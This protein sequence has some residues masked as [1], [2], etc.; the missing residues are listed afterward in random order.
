MQRFSIMLLLLAL[1]SRIPPTALVSL[2]S[3][4]NFH[5]SGRMGWKRRRK[6]VRPTSDL[7]TDIRLM[8]AP[9]LMIMHSFS[10]PLGRIL[11]LPLHILFTHL[12]ISIFSLLFYSQNPGASISPC[13]YLY[14]LPPFT[15]SH[16]R[17]HFPFPD[18]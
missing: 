1:P 6:V 2:P 10:L 4:I 8:C 3:A 5:S 14:P 15:F 9:E 17:S 13:V 18:F 7:V 12:L 11:L 16:S